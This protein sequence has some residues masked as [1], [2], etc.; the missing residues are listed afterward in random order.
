[1]KPYKGFL[2]EMIPYEETSPS[3]I[4]DTA[5]LRFT[6]WKARGIRASDGAQFFVAD[7]R[8]AMEFIDRG[9][10]PTGQTQR[11]QGIMSQIRDCRK[12]LAENQY[13]IEGLKDTNVRVNERIDD[14]KEQLEAA[15]GK[16]E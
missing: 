3:G 5:P 12:I 8:A 1:M 4:P 15:G 13:A 11:Q 10:D 7:E 14:L 16:D 2:I 6:R 9:D